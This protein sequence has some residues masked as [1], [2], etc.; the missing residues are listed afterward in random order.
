[1]RKLATA[2]LSYCAAVFLAHYALPH[3]ALPYLA[4]VMAALAASGLLFRG[5]VRLRIALIT[6]GA[7]AGLIWSFAFTNIFI[8]PADELS[9][10][11]LPI[12]ATV[13][14]YSAD[15]EDVSY[16]Y[17]RVSLD[18]MPTAR[19]RLSA[20]GGGLSELR[21][22]D[23]IEATVRMSSAA[24]RY[25]METDVFTSKGTFLTGVIRGDVEVTGRSVFAFLHF[26]KEITKALKAV[27]DQCLPQ[28]VAGFLKAL[29]TGDKKDLYADAELTDAMSKAGIMHVVAISGMHV[30]FLISFVRLMTGRRRRT[31]AIAIPLILIF[32][33]MTGGSASVIR[34]AFMQIC[35]LTA[36][37]IRRESDGLTSLSAVL[38]L[39]LLINPASAGSA[40]L[41]MSFAAM[42]G[43][44]LVTP[45]VHNWIKDFYA[46]KRL[47]K[48]AH[49]G[50]ALHFISSSLSS[51]IGA[52]VFTT[53]LV[54][55]HFGYISLYSPL[56]NLLTL[57]AVSVCFTLGYAVCLLGLIWQALGVSAGW[58]LAWLLRYVTLMAEL[59]AQLPYAAVY[60]TNNFAALWLVF[61]YLVFTV[62]YALKGKTPFRPVFPASISICALC[63][64]IFLSSWTYS[65]GAAVTAVDVGQ[66]A[67]LAVFSG[68]DTV[69]IDC[70][71][72]GE[73]PGAAGAVAEFLL[74]KGR[75]GVDLLILTH[76]HS[77]HVN[78]VAELMSRVEVRRVAMPRSADD[79]DGMFQE[80]I[81]AA[82]VNGAQTLF[83]D[84]D[85][86]VTLGA[87][88]LQLFAPIG[89]SDANER[90]LIILGAAEGFD[91]LVT[92]DADSSIERRL[93]FR[94]DLPE[95]ELL[96]AGHHGSR[97]STCDELLEATSPEVAV[98]SVGHNSY[99]HPAPDTMERLLASGAEVYRTDLS[100]NITIKIN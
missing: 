71:G 46:E 44:I 4:A 21:P 23:V 65:R 17:V 14:D 18:G 13:L 58:V 53:P 55:V 74:G 91:F 29:L 39:L 84:E 82:S 15:Y 69:V 93:L 38:T 49:G 76:F 35:L 45:R 57:W 47:G 94:N 11:D 30:A 56:T 16:V 37:L 63:A 40:G 89:A 80:I 7:A 34:A 73:L 25:D 31:A 77:D 50:R 60:T 83:I 12:S 62:S 68:A 72:K 86:L 59:V 87:L 51:S 81:E 52:L 26:P 22:G 42:A 90:G 100:G 6:L 48:S 66:G 79:G 20:Y 67:S 1:M 5:D 99:G 98:I 24:K 33:P 54:A 28:D 27:I 78:G 19:A 85:T 97:Y 70:G 41:Q 43:I 32:I 8:A 61:T 3:D 96:V 64:V 88:K 2:A 9:A 75:S 92:G 36:P 95:L 10:D